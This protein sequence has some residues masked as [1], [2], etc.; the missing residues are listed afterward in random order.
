MFP[1]PMLVSNTTDASTVGAPV[2]SSRRRQD[3]YRLQAT[4]FAEKLIELGHEDVVDEVLETTD[5]QES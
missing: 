2:E 3:A 4:L 5:S 1:T